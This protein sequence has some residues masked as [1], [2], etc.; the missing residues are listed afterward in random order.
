M[1]KWKGIMLLLALITSACLL[2]GCAAN[3]IKNDS[4]ESSV[5]EASS[6]EEIITPI[7]TETPESVITPEP[8][9]PQEDIPEGMAKSILTGEYVPEAIGKRRPVAFMIDNVPGAFPHFGNS[10]ASVYIEAP[11]EAELTRECI[12]FEDYDDLGRI[13]SLRSCR[14]Y[15][16]SYALGFDSV[17]CH[18]GQ[19]AYAFVYLENDKVDNISGLKGYA[20]NFFYRSSD[21]KAPHNAHTSGKGINDAIEYLGYRKEIKADFQP[22]FKFKWVGEKADMTDGADAAYASA[23][24][25]TTKSWFEYN[26]ED[27]M[28]YRFQYGGPEVDGENGEQIKVKNLIFEFEDATLYHDSLYVHFDTASKGKGIY[29]CEGKAIPITWERKNYYEPAVYYR[30]DGTVLEMTPGKT[31]VSLVKNKH[32][33]RCVI[34]PSKEEAVCAV[35]PQVQS[36]LEAQ[37]A[38]WEANYKANEDKIREE[39]DADLAA[40]LAAHGGISKCQ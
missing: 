9:V 8:V 5:A 26:A 10:R 15:F 39:L 27:G 36:A 31:F 34:G 2:A 40:S 18:Y 14:D 32:V 21:L 20:G 13:G 24:F 4:E 29:C 6:E 11:V 30:N 22:T 7:P 19:A 23:G 16:L 37:N 35:T 1:R 12:I 28:Y 3:P 33:G 17:F 25:E 38:S